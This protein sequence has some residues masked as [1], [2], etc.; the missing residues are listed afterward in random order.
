[1]VTGIV[2]ETHI[3]H[4]NTIMDGGGPGHQQE[5][6]T[7]QQMILDGEYKWHA[8]I[9]DALEGRINRFE[10]EC[11]KGSRPQRV[12]VVQL[13]QRRVQLRVMQQAVS[14]IDAEFGEAKEEDDG[15]GDIPKRIS[16]HILVQHTVSLVD[17]PERKQIDQSKSK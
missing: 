9:G 16:S 12:G 1:M 5:E 4:V 2:E 13:V 17:T 3:G 10:R 15:D 14:P 6:Q 7:V 11:S 8:H